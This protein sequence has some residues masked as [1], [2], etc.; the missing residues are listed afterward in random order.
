MII[1]VN[2]NIIE[3][4]SSGYVDDTYTMVSS[5]EKLIIKFT[6]LEGITCINTLCSA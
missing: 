2:D 4:H 3:L 5:T 6:H 1:I